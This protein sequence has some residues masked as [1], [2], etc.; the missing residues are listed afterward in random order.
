MLKFNLG[1]LRFLED[2]Y[3]YLSSFWVGC[4]ILSGETESYYVPLAILGLN[5][6]TEL[7]SDSV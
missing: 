4:T 5:T 6:Y 3:I 1:H 7:A 2:E